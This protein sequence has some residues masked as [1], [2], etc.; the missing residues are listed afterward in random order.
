MFERVFNVQLLAQVPSYYTYDETFVPWKQ[1]E[2]G[3]PLITCN[4]MHWKAPATILP[5]QGS[6]KR[7]IQTFRIMWPYYTETLLQ[8]SN[9]GKKI[10]S[11]GPSRS[12]K[13]SKGK[14]YIKGAY[15]HI[16]FNRGCRG[17]A[18]EEICL[19]S[20]LKEAV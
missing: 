19:Q 2:H 7:N 11:E 8:H 18:Q 12:V 3:I 1:R 9:W 5:V 20:V 13:K 15:K 14:S 10:S 16:Y 4:S 17:T 6:W